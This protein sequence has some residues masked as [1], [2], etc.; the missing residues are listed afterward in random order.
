MAEAGEAMQKARRNIHI[1]DHM[2]TQTYPLVKDPKL[3]LAVMDN[4]ELALGN[5]MDALLQFERE[6]KNIPPYHDSFDAKF[7][8]LKLRLAA[9]HKLDADQLTMIYDV[10]NMIAKHKDS[11]VEFT[12]QDKFVICSEEYDLTSISTDQMKQFIN[13]AKTFLNKVEGIIA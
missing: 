4:V 3:L 12:R 10:R 11:P 7:N 5:G 2:L 8:V 13:K 6:A 1:A 9:K